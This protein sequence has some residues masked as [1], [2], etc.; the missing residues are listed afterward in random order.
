MTD[1]KKIVNT[2]START[3]DLYIN[4]AIMLSTETFHHRTWQSMYYRA[5]FQVSTDTVSFNITTPTFH[6]LFHPQIVF[7][8]RF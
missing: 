3:I 8:I 2:V 6:H 4:S 1:I 5:S 7:V